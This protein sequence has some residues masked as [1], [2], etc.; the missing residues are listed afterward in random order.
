MKQQNSRADNLRQMKLEIKEHIKSMNGTNVEPN[1]DH[2][3][4]L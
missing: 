1:Y 3:L 4:R 2:L